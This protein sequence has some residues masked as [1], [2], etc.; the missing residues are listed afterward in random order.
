MSVISDTGGNNFDF[1]SFRTGESELS[2]CIDDVSFVTK[3][4][5]SE[6]S[7]NFGFDNADTS[8]AETERGD[9]ARSRQRRNAVIFLIYFIKYL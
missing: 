7:D 8:S 3:F 1:S 6:Y 4:I 9:A 5:S 2:E